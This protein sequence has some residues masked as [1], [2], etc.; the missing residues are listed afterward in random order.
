MKT[1]QLEKDKQEE[2][3][4]VE[5]TDSSNESS[6]P[7]NS[8]EQFMMAVGQ[9]MPQNDIAQKL[10]EEHI[11]KMLANDELELKLNAKSEN[12]KIIIYCI[13]FFGILA[14]LVFLVVM[15][16]NN[17]DLLEKIIAAI[18]GFGAGALSGYGFG[19]SKSNQN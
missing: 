17:A 12:T 14:F 15:L 5:K 11:T 9:I 4:M 3:G 13:I 19:K 8:I 1:E 16:K 2:I 7:F 10:T 6:E 18:V